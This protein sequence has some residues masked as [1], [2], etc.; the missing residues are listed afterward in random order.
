M[1]AEEFETFIRLM[2]K[3]LDFIDSLT[4]KERELW[5]KVR[6]SEIKMRIF[7]EGIKQLNYLIAKGGSND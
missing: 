6:E 2:N 5:N 4:P 3:Y 7:F 1:D